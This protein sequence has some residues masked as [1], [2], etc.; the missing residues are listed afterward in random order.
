M[1]TL[2]G[3]LKNSEGLAQD[4]DLIKLLINQKNNKKYYSAIC[5]SPALVF[6]PNGLL[7][8]LYIF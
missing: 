3:G 1:I 6:E 5:A 8:N 2:P 7:G 4:K